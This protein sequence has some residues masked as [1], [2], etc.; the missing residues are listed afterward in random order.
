M[1]FGYKINLSSIQAQSELCAGQKTAVLISWLYGWGCPWPG[2]RI[3]TGQ[4]LDLSLIH[5]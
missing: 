1:G 5:I 3:G 2:V 4:V